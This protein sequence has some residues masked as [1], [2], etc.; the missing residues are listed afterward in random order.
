LQ[1]K[2]TKRFPEDK[3]TLIQEQFKAKESVQENMVK[4]GEITKIKIKQIHQSN[5]QYF[6]QSQGYF[7]S[8]YQ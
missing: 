2:K 8:S 4:T 6:N 3:F 7:F 5:K 1:G